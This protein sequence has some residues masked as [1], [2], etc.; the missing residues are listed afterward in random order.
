M[1]LCLK[2]VRAVSDVREINDIDALA[3]YRTRWRSLL[4]K[5][6]G[7][8]FFQS[9]E[10]LEVYWRHFGAGQKLRVLAVFSANKLSGILPLVVRREPTRVGSVRILTY[11]L[12]DWGTTYGPIGPEPEPTLIAGLE[13]VRSTR[14]D[15]DILELRW[16]DAEGS[17]GGATQCALQAAEFPYYRTLWSRP[18]I[19]EFTGTWESYW[20]SRTSKW[21]NNLRRSQ[22]RLREF[23]ELVYVH[24]R[25][26]GEGPGDG[27]PR[28][29]LYDGCEQ[30]AGRSWQGASATGTTLSHGSIQPFLREAHTA[31]ARFG[32]VDLHLM[33]LAGRPLAFAY[34]Y[35]WRGRVDGLRAGYDAAVSREGAGNVLLTRALEESCRCGDHV[36]DLGLESMDWKRNLATRV[37][38]IYRY[39]HFPRA[40]LRAQLLRFKRSWQAKCLAKP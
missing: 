12:H 9:L 1:E 40:A 29:D 2:E 5:T 21:R 24:Y 3:D 35:H 16:V 10:W 17:D 22:R 32:A 13:Y 36:Y 7:A 30:L 27:S 8:S 20:A 15:W 19:V 4:E 39:S 33:L 37:A 25:P 6:A 18:A 23:G 38:A 31:A 14:R 34:N 11:P 26:L 28:W